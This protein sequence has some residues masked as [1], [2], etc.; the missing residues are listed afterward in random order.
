MRRERSTQRVS[1]LTNAD[2]RLSIQLVEPYFKSVPAIPFPNGAIPPMFIRFL[3]VIAVVLATSALCTNLGAETP[4]TLTEAEKSQGWK[5]LF[6]GKSTDAWRNYKKD[7]VGEGWKI[8]DGVLIRAD[9]GAGDIITKEMFD[10]FEFSIEYRI[11]E[12]GNSG[13]MYHVTEV[14]DKPWHTGPEVQI[15][16]NLAGHDPQKAGWL[17]QLYKTETDTAKPAGE[18]NQLRILITPDK[19][20]H[21]MNGT[22]YVEYI[23]GSADWNEKVAASKFSKFPTFGKPTSGHICLQ[24]HNNLVAFRNIKIRPI[25]VTK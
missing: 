19:C 4:N 9:K 24:D 2:W 10:A 5:L 20:E 15:Q 3:S 6:D 18:W 22:K 1:E 13:L 12:G 7:A 8:E 14:G 11:S 17:Y 25:P 23:K 21:Y 16:D